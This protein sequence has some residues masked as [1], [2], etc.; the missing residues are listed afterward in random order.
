MAIV[1]SLQSEKNVGSNMSV[2]VFFSLFVVR[3][4]NG[5]T[6]SSEACYTTVLCHKAF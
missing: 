1:A 2:S 5:L 6:L 4:S 3:C